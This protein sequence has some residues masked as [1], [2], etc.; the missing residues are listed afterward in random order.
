MHLFQPIDNSAQNVPYAAEKHC[1]AVA[2]AVYPPG[3]LLQIANGFFDM[4]QQL[5]KDRHADRLQAA[6]DAS[7]SLLHLFSTLDRRL[8]NLRLGKFLGLYAFYLCAALAQQGYKVI[9]PAVLLCN[10]GL[11]LWAELFERIGNLWQHFAHV[12]QTAVRLFPLNTL[13][14]QERDKRVIDIEAF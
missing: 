6:F 3:K 2:V 8:V 11:L 9:I 14:I 5:F 10:D 7:P 1:N 4:R 13:V 12:A